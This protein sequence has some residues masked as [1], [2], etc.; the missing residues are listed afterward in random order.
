VKI[1]LE[2]K[3]DFS[4]I[5][6]FEW[7]CCHTPIPRSS[8]GFSVRKSCKVSYAPGMGFRTRDGLCTCKRYQELRRPYHRRRFGLP[9]FSAE[10]VQ[11]TNERG[12]T[13]TSKIPSK[14]FM[15]VVTN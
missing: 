11:Q 9:D 3:Y 13:D 14:S 7:N 15:D 6:A 10:L 8:T 5:S 12:V 1:L 4:H 2:I